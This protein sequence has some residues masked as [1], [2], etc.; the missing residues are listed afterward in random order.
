MEQTDA[1]S[2]EE[3]GEPASQAAT[4]RGGIGPRSPR[5][6]SQ[7]P[8]K[9]H[10]RAATPSPATSGNVSTRSGNHVGTRA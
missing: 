3:E 7:P 6:T 5:S 10:T 9:N 2:G 4:P 8:R 1:R